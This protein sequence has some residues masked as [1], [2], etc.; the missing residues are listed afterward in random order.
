MEKIGEFNSSFQK[1][2]KKDEKIREKNLKK[3]ETV[4][5]LGTNFLKKRKKMTKMRKSKGKKEK[6]MLKIE[7]HNFIFM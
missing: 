7:K 1:E 6:K 3:R 2:R 4:N 5:I